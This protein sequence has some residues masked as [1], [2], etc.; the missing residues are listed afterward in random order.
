MTKAQIIIL[1]SV[2][3]IVIIFTLIFLGVIPGLKNNTTEPVAP[4]N[5]EIKLWG[6]KGDE[7][8]WAEVIE[9]F[10]L[11]HSTVDVEYTGIDEAK[12]ES[13]LIDNLA[14]NTGPDIFLIHND[15]LP[16]HQNKLLPAPA[17][18]LPP[19]R[20]L[21][22]FPKV[23]TDDF[24]KDEKVF[25]LPIAINTLALAYNRGIFDAKQ[26]FI[27]PDGWADI[28]SIIPRLRE[29]ANG[30]ITKQAISLG[31]ST[32]SVTNAPDILTL[33]M[34]QLEVAAS[35]SENKLKQ[36]ANETLLE[37]L[38][39]YIDFSDPKS[40][41]YTL[42]DVSPNSLDS[43]AQGK[44]A[45]I[46]VYPQDIQEIK[47]KNQVAFSNLRVLPMPQIDR[48]TPVNLTSFWGLTVSNKT[49]NYDLAWDFINSATTN[50]ATASA[51]A[52]I[53]GNSPAL[54][55]SI[56][57][58]KDHPVLKVFAP[59]ILN[60]KT[61]PKIEEGKAREIFD[62]MI[63][64]AKDARGDDVRLKAIV[65]DALGKVAELQPK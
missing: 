6:L 30:R 13:F 17:A 57:D 19:D 28:K 36:G 15:W 65:N 52:T 58:F 18:I 50:Q 4:P 59:Q 62:N 54:R 40:K 16:K 35:N 64:L 39:F 49:A 47:S 11:E 31:G 55:A 1:G 26:V 25:A 32:I 7:S 34:L 33:L 23:V 27:I 42:D 2:G 53:S 56:N 24:V 12:Y 45:M 44:S 38:K 63:K 3:L 9:R 21:E 5:T 61:Y 20:I 46:L 43:F 37:A 48:N 8:A 22:I 29:I 14:A 10:S 51:Y 60:A 41:N